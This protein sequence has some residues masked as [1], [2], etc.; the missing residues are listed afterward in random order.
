[1][2]EHGIVKQANEINKSINKGDT[3]GQNTSGTCLLLDIA[4][5]KRGKDLP[6][7]RNYP[8]YTNDRL[9]Y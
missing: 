4:T 6:P 5:Y 9:S 3:N 7:L 2:G 8:N 1:M